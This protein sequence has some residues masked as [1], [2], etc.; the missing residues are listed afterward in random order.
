MARRRGAGRITAWRISHERRRIAI[1]PSINFSMRMA[2]RSMA[3]LTP[4]CTRALIN[5]KAA[6]WAGLTVREKE[7]VERSLA[8]SIYG[9]ASEVRTQ[10]QHLL[11][12]S[13]AD[14]LLITGGAFDVAA[15]GESDRIL[16]GLFPQDERHS[17]DDRLGFVAPR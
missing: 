10:V 14:E 4:S 8:T 11:A 17:M 7:A 6:E 16:A 1:V 9:T 12:A 2:L 3:H 13:G 5:K 15:Q